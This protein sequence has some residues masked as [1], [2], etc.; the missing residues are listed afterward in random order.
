MKTLFLLLLFSFSQAALADWSRVAETTHPEPQ[1]YL[2]LDS[3]KQTGPMAIM[4]RVWELRNYS[5]PH[6]DKVRSIKRLSEYDCMDRR[7]RVVQELWFTDPWAKGESVP[8]PL[9]DDAELAW[10]PIAPRSI[11]EIILDEMCPHENDG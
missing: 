11:N 7:H 2:D 10:R 1:Q 6:H 9:R 4:R 5:T 8:P 3:V